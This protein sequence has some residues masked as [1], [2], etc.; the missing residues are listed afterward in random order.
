MFLHCLQS[1]GDFK[2]QS[3]ANKYLCAY[4]YIYIYICICIYIYIYTH[5]YTYKVIICDTVN[6]TEYF[7]MI[8]WN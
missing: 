7:K 6:T 3:Q 1:N 8:L 5:I 4:I 2:N